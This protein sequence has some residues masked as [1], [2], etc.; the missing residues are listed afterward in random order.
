MLF[1][2][3]LA[4]LFLLIILLLTPMLIVG[5]ITWFGLLALLLKKTFATVLITIG[6]IILA[7]GILI[8]IL[9]Q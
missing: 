8:L 2:K 6:L 7:I 9:G 1:T 5:A 3:I 4:A